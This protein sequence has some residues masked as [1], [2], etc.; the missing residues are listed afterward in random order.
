MAVNAKTVE[1]TK[2]AKEFTLAGLTMPLFVPAA[3]IVGFAAYKNWLPGNMIGAWAFMIL[4][5]ALLNEIGNRLPIIKSYLGGGPIVIIFGSAAMVTYGLM[6]KSTD[7]IIRT[8][9]S[10]HGFLNWY[11]AALITGSILGMSRELLIKASARYVPAII[12]GIV[13]S[14][15]LVSL[16]GGLIGYGWKE[17]LFFI[18]IPIMGGGMGAG[19]VPLSQIYSGPFG[20]DAAV[21]LAIMVPAVAMGNALAIISAGLLNRF[22]KIKPAFS[23]EGKLMAGEQGKET[24]KLAAK[25]DRGV[26]DFEMMGAGLVLAS[27]FFILG[28]V[29]EKY[30]PQLH[31][32]ALMIIAVAVVKAL[33]IMPRKYEIGAYQWFQFI[34]KN[35]TGA[36]LI[37]IGVAFTSLPDIIKA[38]T[39][40]YVILIFVTV[41][42]AIVGSGFIGKL[43]GFYPIESS[44][45]AGLC[46]ANMGGTGDVATL[47]AAER[48]ELMP[49]AQISSRIGGA[50]MLLL[51]SFL[52]AIL[53]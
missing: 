53:L 44:I 42:G 9:M 27:C 11:I 20:Q 13:A 6:P 18:G 24:A 41:V 28:I 40:Q 37:G 50:V 36:L 17:A 43:V 14:L 30:I 49:F 45:T 33:G 51:A 25:D 3:V 34:M 47:S 2:V 22:G 16:V 26:V 52:T 32:F 4:L 38:F 5:G 15:G 8:F 7:T 46:M 12:G 21:V 10:G 48:M 35:L 29:L 31:S 23:G 39:P 19:A 1:P